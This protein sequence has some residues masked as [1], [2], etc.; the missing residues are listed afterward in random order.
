MELN[1]RDDLKRPFLEP[2]APDSIC[3][4]IPEPVDKLVKKKT[5]M[6]RIGNIKCAS[7]VTSIES[8]LG[9]LKGVESVSVSSIQSQAAIEYVPK[10]IN[11]SFKKFYESLSSLCGE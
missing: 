3:I 2:G 4:T 6:F 1:G 10:L 11:V 7:C 5:V 9:E 8:V